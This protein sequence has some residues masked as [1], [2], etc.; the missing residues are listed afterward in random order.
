MAGKE[1]IDA[2]DAALTALSDQLTRLSDSPVPTISAVA[3]QLLALMAFAVQGI[4][5]GP[6]EWAKVA[7]EDVDD[8]VIATNRATAIASTVQTG[9]EMIELALA[10]Q[11]ATAKLKAIN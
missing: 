5:F 2:L 11:A 6:S 9:Q 1:K 10:F 7:D 4:A 3:G 8:A